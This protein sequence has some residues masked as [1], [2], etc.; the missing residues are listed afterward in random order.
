MKAIVKGFI[1]ISG[2][3]L[4][5]FINSCQTADKERHETE[6]SRFLVTSP[7]IT[8]T[9]IT[10]SYVCQIRSIRHIELRA[11]ERGYL[12]NIYVDEGQSVKKGQIM[13][14]ILP[15]IYQAELQKTKAEARLAEIEYLNTKQLADSNV[16]SQNELAMT[17]AKYEKARAEQLLSQA[18][19]NFTEIRAPFDGIMDRL[20]VRPGSLLEEGEL[21]TSL[22]DNSE[23]WVYFNVPEAEYLDY[24]TRVKKDS[25]MTVSLKMA[26][27]KLFPYHGRVETIEADFNNET[28][29]IAFRATFP[30]PERVLRYG[31]TGTILVNSPIKNAVVIPQKATF[32][33]LDKKYVYVLNKDNQ[34]QTRHINIAEEL[35]H[36][37]VISEGL[38]PDDKILL[39][40]LRKVR[41][42]EE[43]QFEFQDPVKVV[44]N[45][46]LYAE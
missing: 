10:R 39:E 13:F 17:R 21:L 46:D 25:V 27:G 5:S 20:H 28:G 31:E 37:Y 30:N 19:L 26:N 45:L 23:M 11:L 29:N 15:L 7:L 36:I 8:D 9:S 35:S 33:V 41:N 18:H 16:V 40:G 1:I 42:G 12:Q 14:Q 4:A 32:E 2:L 24:I 22:A 6:E 34:L 38:S 3:A 43:I 44:S